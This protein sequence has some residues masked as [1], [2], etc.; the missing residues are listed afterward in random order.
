MRIL[1]VE[2]NKDDAQMVELLL[3]RDKKSPHDI[4]W[5]ETIAD[6]LDRLQ[7]EHFD[8]ALVDLNLPDARGGEAVARLAGAHIEVPIVV[9][10][11]ND[12]EDLAVSLIEVGA[13]D[14]LM[15][16]LVGTAGLNRAMRYAVERKATEVSLR[17]RASV[18]ILTGL[19]NRR[20]FEQQLDRAMAQANRAGT[21]VAVILIDLDHFK[22]VNDNHG[23]AAGD[24]VLHVLGERLRQ[25][26]RI[27]DI[28]A[29]LGGD[30][31]AVVL[32][33][34]ES[35][36]DVKH[37]VLRTVEELRKPVNLQNVALPLSL[38]IG[39]AVYPSHAADI[40][41]MLRCADVAMYQVKKQGRNGFLLYDE[42]ME[43]SL[44]ER[45]QIE[46]EIRAGL[47]NGQFV[48]HYQP[49]VS[50]IDG[51]L[52]GLETV[53]RWLRA[54]KIYA[55]PSEYIPLAQNFKLIRELGRQIFQR[56]CAQVA[57]WRSRGAR[58]TIPVSIKIDS[59]ELLAPEYADN[60]IDSVIEHGIDAASIRL[61]LRGDSST[62]DSL[63]IR[64]NLEKL[65]AAGFQFGVERLD[66]E[67]LSRARLPT[68][69]LCA[70]KLTKQQTTASF[71]EKTAISVTRGL[72]KMAQEIGVRVVGEGVE[73]ARQFRALQQL[74]C[75]DAQGYFI[76]RPMNV[77]N[78]EKWVQRH[79]ARQQQRDLSMTGRFRLPPRI[80]RFEAR[81]RTN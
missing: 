61:E 67:F 48:P 23:H 2:D 27:S 62:D 73:T 80:A 56:V 33:D 58:M 79:S 77:H 36:H 44:H 22:A 68:D 52:T 74:G 13:Q 35:V 14:Y 81:E 18:D 12:D 26:L 65:G 76:A 40:E 21:M 45:A 15:K 51:R 37:W 54:D 11:G 46:Q 63:V 71:S 6:G 59:Q 72:I 49:Q 70:L 75:D 53:C 32:E 24:T 60:A 55:Q 16:G 1:L 47:D 10:S 57:Q 43:N 31:F 42:R 50:L 41:A 5:V 29:R 9:L 20:E 19:A 28:G 69:S 25:S 34:L 30:E 38:S 39:A 66:I 7:G 17:E 78:L 3:A 8:I 4:E 64:D